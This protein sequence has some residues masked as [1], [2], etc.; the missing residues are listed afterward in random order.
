MNTS[1]VLTFIGDDKPGLVEMV[2]QTV[3]QNGGNW[4]ESRMSQMAGKFAGIVRITCA[5][6]ATETLFK[7]LKQLSDAGLAVS[8]SLAEASKAAAPCAELRI[9]IVGPDR[10]GIISE[11]SQSL[12]RRGINVSEL[13]SDISS[14][15]MSGEPLFEAIADIQLPADLDRDD[16]IDSLEDTANDLALDISIQELPAS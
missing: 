2:A 12:A 8:V 6:Q 9:S 11:V 7:E 10:P 5:E 3:T 1:I 14:V 4:L 16:L 15:P 13:R